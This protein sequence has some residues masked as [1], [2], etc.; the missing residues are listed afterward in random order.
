MKKFLSIIL[1]CILVFSL[2][3][4]TIQKTLEN[5]NHD[6]NGNDTYEDDEEE[7]SENQR[8]I[9]SDE[10]LELS[11]FFT[12]FNDVVVE[13]EPMINNYETDDFSMFDISLDYLV[14]LVHVSN[15]A[16]YDAGVLFAD[17]G[18]YRKVDGDVIS[19][20]KKY[21][22]EEDGFSPDQQQ[23][24]VITESGTLDTKKNQLYFETIVER[25]GLK[26]TRAVS[27]TVILADGTF[28]IQFLEVPFS[29]VERGIEDSGR[30]YF[31]YVSEE[32]LE[33][34]KA[35]FAF[36]VN[37]TY[38]SIFNKGEMETVKMAEGYEKVR[39]M[40]VTESDVDTERY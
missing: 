17:E 38:K 14:P 20:G 2:S 6:N 18:Q 12:A 16:Y 11:E 3:A 26:V 13:H 28:L 39:R 15:I 22:R 5:L 10:G 23:G 1:I 33:V 35:K 19:F 9:Y 24:D 25:N 37:F 40:T 4:C 29:Q 30:A 8:G 34:I 36:D 32:K 31:M 21:T 7:A 27:E